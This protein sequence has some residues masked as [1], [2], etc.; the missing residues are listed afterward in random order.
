MMML[1]SILHW[2]EN[3]KKSKEFQLAILDHLSM[4]D[5]CAD[6]YTWIPPDLNSKISIKIL[7][8]DKITTIVIALF[9]LTFFNFTIVFFGVLKIERNEVDQDDWYE[10]YNN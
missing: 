6:T 2:S 1:F 5:Y 4:F 7:S 10:V 3:S 9:S 8:M